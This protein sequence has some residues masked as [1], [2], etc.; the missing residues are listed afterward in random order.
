M[1]TRDIHQIYVVPG[2]V[3]NARFT[4]C[5]LSGY[6][7]TESGATS[8]LGSSEFFPGFTIDR[9]GLPRNFNALLVAPVLFGD[10]QTSVATG[11]IAAITLSAGIMHSSTTGGTF[12]V[13]SSG[14]W[15][16]R[17][18]L[19]RQTTA[20]S[21]ATTATY[22]TAIQRDVGLTSAIGLGGVLST[23]TSTA[24]GQGVSAGASS[25]S[26][27][28]WAGAGP[29]FS[30]QGAKRYI[31]CALRLQHLTTGDVCSGAGR[32]HMS[33]A[34]IFSEPDEAQPPYAPDKRILVT[35]GCAT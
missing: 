13:Y 22:F 27:L 21:T 15:L 28:Y 29:A 23:T 5:E 10:Y 32:V 24:A 6:T 25:T 2:F 16:D 26:L 18:G 19:W 20:T 7:C 11:N 35:S 33:A 8:A 17:K 3:N 31:K 30:L 1:I 9:L 4:G 12:T 14:D 34:A